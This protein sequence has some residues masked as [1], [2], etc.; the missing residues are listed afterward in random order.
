MT[1]TRNHALDIAKILAA[2]GVV[3]LHVKYSTPAGAFFNEVAWPTC[4]P[5]FYVASLV[6][7]FKRLPI[8]APSVVLSKQLRRVVIPYLVWT[9]IYIALLQSKAWVVHKPRPLDPVGNILYGESSVHL[10]FL[11]T[12]LC[13][14]LIA[15]AVFQFT[16]RNDGTGKTKWLA[17][18]ALLLGIGYLV[19]GDIQNR[20]GCKT[21]GNF[22]AAALFIGVAYT[23]SK[24]PEGRFN[25]VCGI[26]GA[27]IWIGAVSLNRMNLR[28]DVLHYPLI[29]ALGGIGF[30]MLASSIHIHI[31]NEKISKALTASF[32]I[33]LVHVI[34]LEGFEF[35]VEVCAKG[36]FDYSFWVKLGVSLTVFFGAWGITLLLRR[37]RIARALLLGES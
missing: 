13:Y 32:G 24:K 5:F 19:N 16:R 30:F 29:L 18:S 20:F 22:I 11:P 28:M 31:K 35:L 4:V 26:V 25:A 2:F 15:W 12:L 8:D 14:Q 7:F 27:L 10:Y 1:K 21:T 33:Y 17:L 9:L 36:N 3:T 6:F 37:F 23:W 34:L